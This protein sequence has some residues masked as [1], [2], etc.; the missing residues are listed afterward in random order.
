[1]IQNLI[2]IQWIVCIDKIK[3]NLSQKCGNKEFKENDFVMVFD[4]IDQWKAYT[5]LI[6]KWLKFYIINNV[7]A[8]NDFYVFKNIDDFRYPNWM[9]HDV[10]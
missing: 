9:N 4:I 10:Y 7:F 5:K 2:I 1:M 6:S 3:C 8:N